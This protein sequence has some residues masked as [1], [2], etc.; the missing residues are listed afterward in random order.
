MITIIIII[1]TIIKKNTIKMII[2]T[3]KIRRNTGFSA[4]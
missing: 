2:I 4:C 1:I 3:I